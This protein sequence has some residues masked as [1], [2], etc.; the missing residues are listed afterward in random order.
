VAET[1]NP[2]LEA[3]IAANPDDINLRRVY[4]DWLIEAGNPRGEL[5]ALQLAGNED[6]AQA[7]L[8]AHAEQLFGKQ[9]EDYVDGVTWRGGFCDTL[10]LCEAFDGI[11]THPS[12]RLLRTLHASFIG[13]FEWL[14]EWLAAGQWPALRTLVLGGVHL[15]GQEIGEEPDWTC[16]NLDLLVPAMPRLEH[17]TLTCGDFR[18]GDFPTLREFQCDGMGLRIESLD[19]LF[20]AKLPSLERLELLLELCIGETAYELLE[21]ATFAPLFSGELFPALREVVLH[22]PGDDH[23]AAAAQAAPLARRAKIVVT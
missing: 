12:V 9:L 22:S 3:Q 20:A 18:I 8:E 17:L 13:P 11:R 5:A 7:L 15:E 16:R 21:T 23:L 6:A 4:A 14:V 19:S 10:E 1:S 2:E